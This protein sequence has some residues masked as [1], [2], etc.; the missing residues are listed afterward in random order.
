MPMEIK[1]GRPK[2]NLKGTSGSIRKNGHRAI[3]KHSGRF[4]N[5]R[6]TMNINSQGIAMETQM[7]SSLFNPNLLKT[8]N[9]ACHPG[10]VSCLPSKFS[11]RTRTSSQDLPE[12]T[13]ATCPNESSSKIIPFDMRYSKQDMQVRIKM[14]MIAKGIELNFN[15]IGFFINLL[16]YRIEF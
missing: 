6:K 12:T 16:I 13:F 2:K 3:M 11:R 8:A 9:R 14:M 10:C 4:K 5:I 1:K 15:F 7:S